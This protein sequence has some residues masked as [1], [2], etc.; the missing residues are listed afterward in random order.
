M[1]WCF[2]DDLTAFARL[3]L[4]PIRL[5]AFVGDEREPVSLYFY[6][7]IT[8]EQV[9]GESLHRAT[10]PSRATRGEIKQL[11]TLSDSPTRRLMPIMWK[12]W[13]R[14]SR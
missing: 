6:R 13:S 8:A 4:E 11:Y 2:A 1:R 10:V 12:I 7:L 9:N 3:H 14:F 5:L